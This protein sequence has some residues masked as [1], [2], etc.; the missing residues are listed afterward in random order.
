MRCGVAASLGGCCYDCEGEGVGVGEGEG[1]DDGRKWCC[2]RDEARDTDV[3]PR[4][5][6][7]GSPL[8]VWTHLQ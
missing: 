8:R 2:G 3:S 5:G 6:V 4:M 7:C 1:E